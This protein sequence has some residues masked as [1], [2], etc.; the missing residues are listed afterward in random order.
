MKEK[1]ERGYEP[2]PH[3]SSLPS[4]RIEMELRWKE[5]GEAWEELYPGR[6]GGSLGRAAVAEGTNKDTS[7]T[8]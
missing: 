4:I 6:D 7:G 1:Y 3:L 8:R 2:L 5:A